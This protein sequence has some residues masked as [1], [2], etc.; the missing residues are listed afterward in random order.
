MSKVLAVAFSDIQIEDWKRFSENHSRLED[1]GTILTKVKDLCLKYDCPALFGGDFFDNPKAINNYV[2]QRTFEWLNAFKR[3]K[4]KIYAIDGNH[5][6]CDKNS[7][8]HRSPNYINTLAEVYS[9]I[10]PVSNTTMV[11]KNV[12]IS[13]IPYLSGNKDFIAEVKKAADRVKVNGSKH[14]LLTHTDYPGLKEPNGKEFAHE[15]IPMDIYKYLE[16]FDLVLNG[17]IHKPQVMY[18]KIVTMGATHQQR[19]SDSGCEMGIWLIKEDM[20]YEFIPLDLPEFKY[21]KQ[22][23]PIP[24]DK[25]FYIEVPNEIEVDNEEVNKFLPTQKPK[26]LVNNYMKQLGIKS[27]KK[28]NLLLKYLNHATD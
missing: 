23:K 27:K 1:N 21:I 28:T 2:L 11:H 16:P 20:S 25:N 9:N 22:G 26:K 14:I 3:H 6:Q 13:G 4:I 7:V 18:K 10:I 24:E 8:S 17:H 15:N 12:F 19:A 5:D